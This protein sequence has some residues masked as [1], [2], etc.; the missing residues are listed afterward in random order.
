MHWK[1]KAKI[2]SAISLLPSSTS[3]TEYYW[4]QRHFGSL[5]RLNPISRI[6]AAINFLK[7]SDNEWKRYTGNRYM[8][9]LRHNDFIRLFESVKHSIV[10][11]QPNMDQHSLELLRS[12]SLQLNERFISKSEDVLAIKEAWIISQKNS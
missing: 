8:N 6:T 3:Y 12:G 9:R 4:F 2:Q 11:A 10:E 1:L 7:Y 5:R